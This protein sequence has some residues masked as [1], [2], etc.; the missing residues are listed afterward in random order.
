MIEI[1]NNRLN[2]QMLDPGEGY[3]GSR[4]DWN[5]FITDVV[6]DGKYVFCADE[7]LVPGEGS[8]GRGIC[9]EFGIQS[10]IGYTDAKVGEGFPKIGTGILERT[11]KEDYDFFK[12]YPVK[13]FET[14]VS[15]TDAGALFRV[16]SMECRGY[17]VSYEKELSLDDN[18]LTISYRLGNTGGKPIETTEYCH[19]FV[20]ID[21]KS[22][23]PDYELQF[24]FKLCGQSVPDVIKV[25]DNRINWRVIPEKVF[26]LAPEGFD[27]E[28]SGFYW[29]LRDI[30][31]GIGMREDCLF[32][33]E[34]IAIWGM[35]HVVS[36]EM[37]IGIHL[38]PGEEMA[39]K[40]IYT[41]FASEYDR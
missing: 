29:E 17:C 34:R 22:I 1:R 31:R 39:W 16:K 11:G 37:F 5:G 30:E 20:N 35:P 41:F 32:P 10:P 40:R 36:P 18:R 26:Y 23:G 28:T 19:N 3:S 7:S 9:N 12:P 14:D 25:T 27:K 13:P 24:P 33:V 15:R 8:G 21:N 4:F 2:V 6:L 38:A